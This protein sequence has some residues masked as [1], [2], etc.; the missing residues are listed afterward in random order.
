MKNYF[1]I[2]QAAKICSVD[3][4]TVN[5]WVT[6]GKIKSYSTPGG[7]KRILFKDL[8]LFLEKNKMPIELT[9]YEE[10]K[11]KILIVDD[12]TGIQEYLKTILSGIFTD[13]E[14]A[15]DGFEAGIK[16]MEFKP[17]LIILD[18]SMP[19]ADGFDVCK[20][21][22]ANPSTRKIK[23]LILT[24]YGTQE[25]QTKAIALGADAFL[26][27]PCPEKDLINQVERL[28]K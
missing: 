9:E 28:L 1:S 14:V 2:P 13:V 16:V 18:L 6:A 25:N 8:E 21:I 26:T 11:T 17:H 7:H 22:K 24:G 12:D 20:T 4:S 10:K 23:I 27:K 15:S 19:M 5:R 3:R